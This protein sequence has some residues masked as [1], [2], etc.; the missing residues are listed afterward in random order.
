MP[1]FQTP[2]LIVQ[3]PMSHSV[4]V[5]ATRI[6]FMDGEPGDAFGHINLTPFPNS[7]EHRE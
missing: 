7:Q 1:I 2:G 4:N 3:V 6:E 5:E